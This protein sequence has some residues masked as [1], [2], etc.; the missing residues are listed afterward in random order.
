MRESE[1]CVEGP[2]RDKFVSRNRR[3]WVKRDQY[4]ADKLSCARS[5]Q[6][7]VCPEGSSE[8]RETLGTVQVTLDRLCGFNRR[9]A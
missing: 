8:L 4:S 3:A 2:F 5:R 1:Y 6:E 7:M 9:M